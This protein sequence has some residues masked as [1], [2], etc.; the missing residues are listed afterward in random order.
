VSAAPK[1]GPWVR[2]RL[3]SRIGAADARDCW[4]WL[5]GKRTN[6]YGMFAVVRDGRWSQTTAHRAS[7]EVFVGAIP[8]G[9]E[10]DHLCRN[11]AC[12]N[13]AH[14]EAV[15]IQENRRRRNEHRTA[16]LRGHPYIAN[17]RQQMGSDGYIS[18]VCRVCERAR[19]RGRVA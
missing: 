7:Y 18:R 15:T 14:L 3:E 12:V 6:G 9:F 1:P 10:V 19:N 17:A 11:R 4:P 13:P 5:G 8:E 2:A 16:C